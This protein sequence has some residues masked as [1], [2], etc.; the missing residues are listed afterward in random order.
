MMFEP[1]KPFLAS[2]YQIKFATEGWEKRGSAAL[3]RQVFCGEQGL[4]DGDDRDAPFPS[5]RFRCSASPPMPWSER[6]A[7]TSIRKTP[8]SGG[9]RGSRYP[10][11]TADLERSAPG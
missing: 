1:F 7:F 3:R 4:F 6:F 9:A 5:L 2:A 10:G 8:A 11:N